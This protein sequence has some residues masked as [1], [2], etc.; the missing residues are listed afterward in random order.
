MKD[1]NLR[2]EALDPKD[3]IRKSLTFLTAV[4]SLT[5]ANGANA[6]TQALVLKTAAIITRD[7]DSCKNLAD[8]IDDADQDGLKGL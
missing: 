1:R 4:A 6:K 3:M 5:I 7:K 8:I 2:V